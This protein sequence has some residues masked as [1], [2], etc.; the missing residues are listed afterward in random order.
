MPMNKALQI[1]VIKQLLEKHGISPDTID[2]EQEIDSTLTLEE[3]VKR[4]SE[5]LG[6]PLT[7]ALEEIKMNHASDDYVEEKNNDLLD[8]YLRMQGFDPSE[9]EELEEEKEAEDPIRLLE[10]ELR[11][12]KEQLDQLFTDLV[13]TKDPLKYFSKFLFPEIIGKQYDP[14]RKAVLLM[15]ATQR[16]RRKRTRLHILIVGKP[17]CGKTE[18]LLWMHRKLNAYFVNAEYVS[19]VGLAG[20]ARGREVTPG[21]LAEADGMILAI[22]EVDKMSVKDQS[23]LLQAMEEG[24]YVIIKGKHRERFRAEVRVIATAND[25]D[26]IQKPL[27]DRFDF[28]FFLEPPSKD[29]RAEN[30]PKL[31]EEFFGLTSTKDEDI[32][33]DYLGW[34]QSFEPEVEDIDKIKEV[35]RSYIKLTGK[36]LSEESYRSLEL[37]ILRIAY[38]L[39]K[40]HKSNVTPIHV[41]KAIQLKDNT[42]TTEQIRYLTAIAK[43]LI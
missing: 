16:D 5:K 35:M 3:N 14:I 10:E 42:L 15:L 31:V 18:I 8:E 1:H 12:H 19:K 17:G 29:E 13:R 43:G 28:I 22:D 27:R 26:K 21:A 32:F 36:D 9:L 4:L 24:T 7:K 25:I 6:I 30:A 11:V 2:I 40:L 38:A 20:D 37:S 23:A 33:Y 41:V 39:A 34:I